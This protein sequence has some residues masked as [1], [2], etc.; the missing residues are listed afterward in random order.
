MTR[1]R[2]KIA[3]IRVNLEHEG[4]FYEKMGGQ[5]ALASVVLYAR[6]AKGKVRKV[7]A[8]LSLSG[9]SQLQLNVVNRTTD[10]TRTVSVRPWAETHAGDK[11][12][13]STSVQ[14]EDD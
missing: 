12:P 5:V 4:M 14:V 6:D 11:V 1:A 13:T 10:T 3:L 7:H 9:P 2:R 8:H